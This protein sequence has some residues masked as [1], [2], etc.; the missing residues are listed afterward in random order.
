MTG[1]REK[2]MCTTSGRGGNLKT[3]YKGMC[4]YPKRTYPNRRYCTRK[5]KQV[6][7]EIGEIAG[8]KNSIGVQKH[9]LPESPSDT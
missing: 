8:K 9:R 1:E 3:I 4:S 6:S 7:E 2:K 5:N